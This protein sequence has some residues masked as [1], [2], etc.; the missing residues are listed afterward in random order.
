[1]DWSLRGSTELSKLGVDVAC[2]QKTVTLTL[3]GE[4]AQERGAALEA[5]DCP[6]ITVTSCRVSDY[7]C[8]TLKAI[9][10]TVVLLQSLPAESLIKAVRTSMDT[11]DMI[12]YRIHG[13]NASK[14]SFGSEWTAL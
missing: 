4:T 5:E 12:E 2:S 7:N 9:L 13:Q 8:E 14:Q 10:K 3:W 11:L 6:V 1:M